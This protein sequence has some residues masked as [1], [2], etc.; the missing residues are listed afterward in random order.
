MLDSLK[1]AYLPDMHFPER[2]I[3]ETKCTR[4]GRCYE[5]CPCYG[6]RWEKDTVPVPVGYGGFEQACINCGNCLVVCPADAITMTGSYVVPEG[7]YQ[8][9]LEKKMAPPQPLVEEKDHSFA[10]IED[11]LTETE[12]IIYTRRSNRL[13]RTR[14]FRGN[15]CTASSR[16]AASRPRRAT[17]SPTSLL[18]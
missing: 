15:C 8:S 18:S 14:R 17:T 10:E 5:T 1:K 12:R 6:Y 9:L 13:S 3:D 2:H 11:S 16:P 7:R 4:C